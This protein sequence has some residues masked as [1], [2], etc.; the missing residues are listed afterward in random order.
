MNAL[1]ILPSVSADAARAATLRNGIFSPP[2]VTLYGAV[3]VI[4]TRHDCPE[5]IRL[6]NPA[7]MS[8]AVN[9]HQVSVKSTSPAA[10]CG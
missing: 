3:S 4:V 7:A 1:C 5:S 10:N 2:V 9:G 8:A 6:K